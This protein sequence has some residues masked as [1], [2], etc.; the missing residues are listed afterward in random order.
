MVRSGFVVPMQICSFSL[1]SE[2]P[3]KN[4]T[5]LDSQRKG[6]YNDLNSVNVANGT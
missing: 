4:D 2:Y 6:L 5:P 1:F 3:D